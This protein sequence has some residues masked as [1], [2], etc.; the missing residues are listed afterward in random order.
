MLNPITIIVLFSTILLASCATK[1]S[2]QTFDSPV[3][4][5]NE[6][7]K[8]KS[9]KSQASKVT[10]IDE[11]RGTFTYPGAGAGRLEF[12]STEDQRTWMGYWILESGLYPCSTEKGGSPFWGEQIFHFNETYNQYTGTWDSCGEGTKYSAKGIR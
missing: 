9:G 7:H 1:P 8:T 10:I 4:M 5:W 11:T 6:K 3:G 12:F 2:G